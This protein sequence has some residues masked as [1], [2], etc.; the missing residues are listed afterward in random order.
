VYLKGIFFFV[1][2]RVGA[3]VIVVT[4]CVVECRCVSMCRCV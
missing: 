1:H 4:V 3:N 2:V